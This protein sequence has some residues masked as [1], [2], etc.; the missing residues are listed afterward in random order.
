MIALTIFCF[1]TWLFCLHKL[2]DYLG[3]YQGTKTNNA[4]LK[5]YIS[6]LT[7]IFPNTLYI[8][9]KLSCTISTAVSVLFLPSIIKFSSLKSLI[10]YDVLLRRTLFE[11]EQVA[12]IVHLHFSC[13]NYTL[14]S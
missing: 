5:K 9:K 3:C 12:T 6:S 2:T 13:Y 8:S 7:N 4:V 11:H 10:S 14:I 1:K